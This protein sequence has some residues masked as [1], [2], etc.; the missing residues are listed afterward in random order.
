MADRLKVLPTQAYS[1]SQP[2]EFRMQ[3]LIQGI[4][5]RPMR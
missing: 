4:G 3:E 2:I 5:A 1:F